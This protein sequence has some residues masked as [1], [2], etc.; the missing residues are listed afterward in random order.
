MILATEFCNEKAILHEEKAICDALARVPNSNEYFAKTILTSTAWR[1]SGGARPRSSSRRWTG[2]RRGPDEQE[3]ILFAGLFNN[4]VKL[5]FSVRLRQLATQRPIGPLD[6]WIQLF[7][8]EI[9][10]L[11]ETKD[12]FAIKRTQ[13]VAQYIDLGLR[14]LFVGD[15][16]VLFL[17]KFLNLGRGVDKFSFGCLDG[18][19]SL[20]KLTGKLVFFGIELL[21]FRIGR[22]LSLRNLAGKLVFFGI[23]LLNFRIDRRLT[24][25]LT[26][27]QRSGDFF[28]VLLVSL[29]DFESSLQQGLEFGIAGRWN[30]R[31]L[32]RAIHGLVIRDLI[33]NVRLV[34]I[35]AI[36]LR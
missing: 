13:L 15:E 7:L 25:R 27:N 21:N 17:R 16:P 24:L 8:T 26:A 31:R 3:P 10:P 4:C 36:E 23:A 12:T 20:R 32:E 2:G 35:R 9:A 1:A 5:S 6:R 29:E 18:R 11:Y 30:E 33:D 14:P 22:Q 28:G 19:P 34:E